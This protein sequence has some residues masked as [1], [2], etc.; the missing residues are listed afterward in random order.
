MDG[1][2]KLSSTP[3]ARSTMRGERCEKSQSSK[4]EETYR[5]VRE[6][7]RHTRGME[8][9]K[10]KKNKQ[11]IKSLNCTNDTPGCQESFDLD[12]DRMRWL[13]AVAH[14]IH[15]RSKESSCSE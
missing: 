8:A 7:E 11:K 3:P 5:W 15:M 14:R 2:M 4:A 13:E 9:I 10:G 6:S 12:N 1:V